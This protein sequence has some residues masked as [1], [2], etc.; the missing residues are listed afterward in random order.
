MDFSLVSSILGLKTGLQSCFIGDF[1]WL[2]DVVFFIVVYAYLFLEVA[3]CEVV[4]MVLFL[5]SK[6][7][8]YHCSNL[9][10]IR[11]PSGS[12]PFLFPV[13]MVCGFMYGK[14]CKPFWK[15]VV[16]QALGGWGQTFKDV[17][18]WRWRL[19][20]HVFLL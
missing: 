20:D 19:H 17:V 12:I 4:V 15:E 16:R 9:V 1:E 18:H 10:Q 3:L 2:I 7:L 13:S 14:L 11:A 5:E 6:L 8:C